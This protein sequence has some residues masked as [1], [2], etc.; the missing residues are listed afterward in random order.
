MDSVSLRV[1]YEEM[2]EYEK[3]PEMQIEL[4]IRI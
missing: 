2:T 3:I 4:G 1:E